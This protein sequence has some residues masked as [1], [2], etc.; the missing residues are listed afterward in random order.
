MSKQKND[1]YHRIGPTT[2]HKI[3]TTLL[4]TLYEACAVEAVSIIVCHSLRAAASGKVSSDE[5][6]S[7]LT[8]PVT[9]A[10]L[11]PARD[12]PG[13]GA[14]PTTQPVSCEKRTSDDFGTGINSDKSVICDTSVLSSV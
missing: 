1:S 10:V 7:P 5:D 12:S 9:R 2:K 3:K 11:S 14:S 8:Q 13:A 4:C 6:W